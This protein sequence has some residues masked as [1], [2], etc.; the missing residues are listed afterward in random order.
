MPQVPR[1]PKYDGG[2]R[3][4]DLVAAADDSVKAAL[5]T[6]KGISE[7]LSTIDKLSKSDMEAIVDEAITLLES[8]YVHLP[9]KRAMHAVDRFSD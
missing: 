4:Q 2:G 1:E 8:F 6:G 9:L 3:L 5:S 7:F